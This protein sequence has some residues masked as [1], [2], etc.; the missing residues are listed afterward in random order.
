MQESAQNQQQ[1]DFRLVI[2]YASAQIALDK[3]NNLKRTINIPGRS[4]FLTLHIE[5]LPFTDRRSHLEE[6]IDYRL[7][8]YRE[9]LSYR[10]IEN[11]YVGR[12]RKMR[13]ATG[14]QRDSKAQNCD[15]MKVKRGRTEKVVEL[16]N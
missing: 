10:I 4:H 1:R 9:Y 14:E 11:L 16:F 6:M 13:A 3:S 2:R 15:N 12:E 7:C 8:E 5:M